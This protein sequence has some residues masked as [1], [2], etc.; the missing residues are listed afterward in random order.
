[1]QFIQSSIQNMES[2]AQKMADLP[3]DTP[4][5]PPYDTP[6]KKL[7]H[8]LSGQSIQTSM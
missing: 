4:E 1:M 7:I 5:T 6:D 3:L 2:V 8:N